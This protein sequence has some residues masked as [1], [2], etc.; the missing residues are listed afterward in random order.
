M[1]IVPRLWGGSAYRW[2]RWN[3]LVVYFANI[4]VYHI[5]N[6]LKYNQEEAKVKYA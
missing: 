1:S 5:V 6:N 4:I 2:S 3:L